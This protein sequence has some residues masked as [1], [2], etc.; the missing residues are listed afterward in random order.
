MQVMG[1]FRASGVAKAGF[2]WVLGFHNHR[3][4]DVGVGVSFRSLNG[5]KAPF[6]SLN[7]DKLP[8]HL[9]PV[10]LDGAHPGSKPPRRI[11]MR[12]RLPASNPYIG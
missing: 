10:C 2:G 5:E 12:D 7:G 1:S 8:S 3:R 4:F 6:Y 9:V 11:P